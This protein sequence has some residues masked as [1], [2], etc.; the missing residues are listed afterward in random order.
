M[1]YIAVLCSCF[2]INR[3]WFTPPTSPLQ[4][5]SHELLAERQLHLVTRHKLEEAEAARREAERERD[6]YRVSD[7]LNMVLM[8]LC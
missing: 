1:S 3:D 2:M 8:R 5:L 6:L 4:V 7:H